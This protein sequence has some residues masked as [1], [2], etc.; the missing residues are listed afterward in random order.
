M[1]LCLLPLSL[2]MAATSYKHAVIDTMYPGAPGAT[3]A[4]GGLPCCQFINVPTPGRHS[5]LHRRIF[6]FWNLVDCMF[7][8]CLRLALGSRSR[9]QTRCS[10]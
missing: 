2:S 8:A 7:E 4:S 6:L 10:A 1:S 3:D 9:G 5:E